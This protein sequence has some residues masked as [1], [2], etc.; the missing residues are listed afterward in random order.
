MPKK[1]MFILRT[2]PYGTKKAEAHYDM[3]LA[4]IAFG[5]IATIVF[6]DDGVFQLLKGQGTRDIAMKNLAK[7]WQVL[8][9][10]P[11]NAIY[12][13]EDAL[14]TRHLQVHDLC[15]TVTP[16]SSTQLSLLM[17]QQDFII[18]I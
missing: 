16:I 14:T 5:H 13:A 7:Q 4:A 12:V 10:L 17:Q 6:C 8:E 1:M 3:L 11:I 18:S 9:L 15:L 2:P